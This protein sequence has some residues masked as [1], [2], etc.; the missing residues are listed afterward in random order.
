MTTGTPLT[1]DQVAQVA[2]ALLHLVVGGAARSGDGGARALVDPA[3]EQVWI[4]WRDASVEQLDQAV[5]SAQRALSPWSDTPPGQR[6]KCLTRLAELI[7]AQA[8]LWPGSRP[9]TSANP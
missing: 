8:T 3:T 1:L 2:D 9:A 7:E 6:A 5:A 4:A